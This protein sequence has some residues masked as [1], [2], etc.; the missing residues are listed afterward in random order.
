MSTNAQELIDAETNEDVG[1]R[2][3]DAAAPVPHRDHCVLV[4]RIKRESPT[5]VTRTVVVATR[6]VNRRGRQYRLRAIVEYRG[7]GRSGH[8]V[9][10][11]RHPGEFPDGTGRPERWHTCDDDAV[12]PCTSDPGEVAAKGCTMLWYE[13]VRDSRADA[14]QQR[15]AIGAGRPVSTSGPKRGRDT[16][17]SVGACDCQPTPTSPDGSRHTP[18]HEQPLA[19]QRRKVRGCLNGSTFRDDT[20][21]LHAKRRRACT[22]RRVTSPRFASGKRR[23][24]ATRSVTVGSLSLRL[25][26]ALARSL[27]THTH[28]P[29][30]SLRQRILGMHDSNTYDLSLTPPD[31]HTAPCA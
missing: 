6:K 22:V 11:V 30:L 12:I 28:T 2:Q 21:M 4:L 24:M 25:T 9:A 10:H 7:A 17:R 3:Q 31:P 16:T 27:S 18:P 5:G 20:G 8:F 26:I 23:Q 15:G 1:S 19:K 14:K 29:S 13:L